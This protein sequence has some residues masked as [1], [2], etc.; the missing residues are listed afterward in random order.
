MAFLHPLRRFVLLID[1]QP[2]RTAGSL[3]LPSAI[4]TDRLDY[5]VAAV[6]SSEPDPGFG[7]G[8]TVLVDDP[9]AGRRVTL[10]GVRYRLVRAS[11]VVGVVEPC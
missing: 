3:E 9:T 10:D 2:K 8:D 1:E 5:V 6:G 11:S 7:V 4:M